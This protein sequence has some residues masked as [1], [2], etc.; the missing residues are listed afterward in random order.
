MDSQVLLA[1]LHSISESLDDVLSASA[2]EPSF[3]ST[4]SGLLGLPFAELGSGVQGALLRQ[5]GLLSPA[6][7]SAL[8]QHGTI[9][10]I[11]PGET[12]LE[13][14]TSRQGLR[15]GECAEPL[16]AH[17]QLTAAQSVK[18]VSMHE[19]PSLGRLCGSYSSLQEALRNLGPVLAMSDA[20]VADR[21]ERSA[22]AVDSVLTIANEHVLSSLAQRVLLEAVADRGMFHDATAAGA[23]GVIIGLLCSDCLNSGITLAFG[24]CAPTLQLAPLL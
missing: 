2:V 22:A 1:D 7:G 9:V 10:K 16:P 12:I 24:L 4:N 6:V 20:L 3:S 15:A 17:V 13:L 8:V 14:S 23:D 21:W 5:L 18:G 19:L 11:V